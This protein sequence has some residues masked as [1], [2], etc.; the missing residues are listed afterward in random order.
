MGFTPD[1][2]PLIGL[3]PEA[4]AH[5]ILAGFSGNGLLVGFH[6]ARTL[7]QLLMGKE[8][9]MP[10]PEKWRVGRTMIPLEYDDTSYH[11]GYTED[12]EDWDED[13]EDED[14]DEDRDDSQAADDDNGKGKEEQIVVAEL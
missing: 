1:E 5:G 4:P 12:C 6:G 7:A 14:E 9:T 11:D 8:P 2:A 10:I 13:E 3:L